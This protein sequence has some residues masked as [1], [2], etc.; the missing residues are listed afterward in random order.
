MGCL[1][2]SP[3]HCGLRPPPHWPLHPTE[4]GETHHICYIK[5]CLTSCDYFMAWPLTSHLS[6]QKGFASYL[7]LTR[8]YVEQPAVIVN[9]Q[10]DI[11]PL[12]KTG[13]QHIHWGIATLATSGSFYMCVYVFPTCT[14]E[15]CPCSTAKVRAAQCRLSGCTEGC[16]GEHG[17]TWRHRTNQCYTI[18]SHSQEN[19]HTHKKTS[20][21]P[22]SV[23][24]NGLKVMYCIH[25]G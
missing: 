10:Q 22:A 21:I 24:S 4:A 3:A 5:Q 12:R 20:L 9:I 8:D 13:M 16:F 14:T 1:L 25:C 7:Q 18:R 2:C 17:G 11:W 19:T 23:N 15:M 6:I